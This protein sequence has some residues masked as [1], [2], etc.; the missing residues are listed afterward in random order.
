M[1]LYFLILLF[2]AQNI[3]Y[4]RI[5]GI[6]LYINN[7]IF[8]KNGN[9]NN[10][11][12]FPKVPPYCN[13]VPVLYAHATQLTSNS[14]TK[15][16]KI[17]APLSLHRTVCFTIDDSP[18]GSLAFDRDNIG[19]ILP[20]HSLTFI[21]LEHEYP[22]TQRYKFALPEVDTSCICECNLNSHVCN[23]QTYSLFNK[24][25]GTENDTIDTSCYNTFSSIRLKNGCSS[26]TQF[27]NVCCK[28]RFN[29][30]LGMSFT[31]VKLNKPNI[32]AL[33]KYIVYKTNDKNEWNMVEDK[34]VKVSINGDLQSKFID[35][36]RTIRLQLGPIGN[37]INTL[38]SGMYFV[39]NNPNGSPMGQDL[40]HQPVNDIDSSSMEKL[41][42][43]RENSFNKGLYE[44][45]KGDINLRARHLVDIIDCHDQKYQ[46][47]LEANYYINKN[48]GDH[49]KFFIADPLH[50][51]YSWIDGAVLYDR[52]AFVNQKES[53]NVVA[54]LSF[55]IK[56]VSN[57]DHRR[58][59]F[60]QGASYIKNFT[61]EIITDDMSNHYFNVTVYEAYGLLNGVVKSGISEED[62]DESSFNILVNEIGLPYKQFHIQLNHNTDLKIE[63]KM[64]CISNEDSLN[65][66]KICKIIKL[67][68]EDLKETVESKKWV[69]GK[70]YCEECNKK[71]VESFIKFLNP[72]AWFKDV[73]T[74]ED[75]AKACMSVVFYFAIFIVIIILIKSCLIPLLQCIICPGYFFMVKKR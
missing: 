20:L 25:D 39:K 23:P 32:Y 43:Y 66:T 59:T 41:G 17:Q 18:N 9:K 65:S 16:I 6:P 47:K 53:A 15:F 5:F 14:S 67:H 2:F 22:I 63:E 19:D 35:N 68:V 3:I 52:F 54:H 33:F 64:I 11:E 31:A 58:V 7:N 60:H 40:R 1:K 29:P 74:I 37:M 71:Q 10:D 4:Q 57:P 13:E 73:N 42:W 26:E 61:G 28:V 38:D 44:V 75:A 56:N 30:Y 55:Y 36:A 46:S 50:T 12:I 72:S 24:C 34:V 27:S 21:R 69:T 70:G 45:Y 8:E 48:T 62:E 49:S 51:I